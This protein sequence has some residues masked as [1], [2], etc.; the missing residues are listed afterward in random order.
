MQSCS[1]GGDRTTEAAAIGSDKFQQ[2]L[3]QT[4]RIAPA[5]R[6]SDE[7]TK[8]AIIGSIC[9]LSAGWA[10]RQDGSAQVSP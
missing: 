7:G 4:I 6:N 1:C 5:M 3:Q 10:G 8:T 2:Q 9:V